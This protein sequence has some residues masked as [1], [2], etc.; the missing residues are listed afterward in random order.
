MNRPN[1]D[2][3]SVLA[4]PL[5]DLPAFEDVA[6]KAGLLR[7]P[8]IRRVEV[9]ALEDKVNVLYDA[10]R[11]S[12]A[13]VRAALG[14]RNFLVPGLAARLQRGVDRHGLTL[15][16]AGSGLLCLASGWAAA[17]GGTGLHLPELLFAGMV[18]LSLPSLLRCL[19]GL[20]RQEQ[21]SPNLMV[22]IIA[23]AA[24][25]AGRWLEATGVIFLSV[26]ADFLRLKAFQPAQMAASN[27]EVLLARQV[28]IREG[29]RTRDVSLA[30][31]QKDQVVLV[32]QGQMVPV[33]GRVLAGKAEIREAALTGE[34]KYQTRV[35]GDAILAGTIVES[36]ALDIQVQRVGKET[37]LAGIDRLVNRALMHTR[38][39]HPF[40]DRFVR[41]Y[42][43]AALAL[44]ILVFLFYGQHQFWSS[45]TQTPV[46][47][48][49]ALAV[50]LGACPLALVLAGPLTVYAGL[51]RAAR[52]GILVKGGDVLEK[53]AALRVLLLDKT[54]TL[55]YAKPRVA[56]IKT[57]AGVSKQEVLDAALF[58]ERQSSHPIARAICEYEEAAGIAVR[59]PDKFMEFEGGGA[60]AIKGD[61][62]VKVGAAWLME[63]GRDL[64][65]QV[66]DW[67]EEIKAQGLS[68]VL[69][70]N[71]VKILGGLVL[72]DA[73]RENAAQVVTAL[74][75]LGLQ[76][77]VMVTGDN[78]ATATRVTDATGLDEAAAECMPDRKLVLIQDEKRKGHL[79]GM[80]GDGINDAPALAA[81]DVGIAMG[82]HSSDLAVEAADVALINNDLEDLRRAV[83]IG[84]RTA[85]FIRLNAAA[86]VAGNVVLI[87]LSATGLVSLM[88]GV[89]IQVILLAAVAAMAGALYAGRES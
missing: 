51:L 67:M 69:V 20:F 84:R 34:S 31:L 40:M 61:T 5:K 70:A 89:L 2:Q 55:T 25:A 71:R 57:F 29:E 21:L 32:R 28:T 15:R 30:D 3:L 50:L 14:A 41:G 85:L 9:S 42:L 66:L 10:A 23:A 62:Y 18:L 86:S 7:N 17:E 8:G 78:L 49:T 56:R 80:V 88:G 39:A 6:L 38:H 68:F 11:I 26:L 44:A 79:V 53:L 48:Q 65:P 24:A 75:A 46:S 45:D 19:R 36:G 12:E 63:D 27:E 74:R 82:T 64:E 52:H 58:V 83:A 73:I 77:L 4:F 13:Q 1:G 16:L 60:C 72:E 33:D 54:G 47:L 59:T 87:G 81:A 37:L 43:L 22:W 35:A 76:R